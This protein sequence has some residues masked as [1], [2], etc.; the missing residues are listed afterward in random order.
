[1]QAVKPAPGT[2]DCK[3]A[4]VDCLPKVRT[5]RADSDSMSSRGSPGRFPSFFKSRQAGEV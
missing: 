2:A 1:M 5:A 4:C 3:R